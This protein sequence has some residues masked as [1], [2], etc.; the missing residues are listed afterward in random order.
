MNTNPDDVGAAIMIYTINNLIE[1]Y[2]DSFYI[3]RLG[4]ANVSE[5]MLMDAFTAA[6]NTLM[7]HFG[8]VDML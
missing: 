4:Q 6:V 3:D 2:P 5:A 1:K 7:K 8:R